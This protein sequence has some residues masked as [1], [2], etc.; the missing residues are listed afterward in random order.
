MARAAASQSE[1]KPSSTSHAARPLI[2][3]VGGSVIDVIRTKLSI[4]R[5]ADDASMTLRCSI[6]HVWDCGHMILFWTSNLGRR[7]GRRTLDEGHQTDSIPDERYPTYSTIMI[8]P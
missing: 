2:L 8:V 1:S 7:P 3:V 4:Q 5:Q 6:Y